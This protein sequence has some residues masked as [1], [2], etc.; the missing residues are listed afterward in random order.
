[1]TM[2]DAV[3]QG[4]IRYNLELN[5]LEVVEGDFGMWDG[6]DLDNVTL[7]DILFLKTTFNADLIDSILAVSKKKPDCYD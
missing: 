3:A 1:M 7:E 4:K 5:T 2:R 6:I